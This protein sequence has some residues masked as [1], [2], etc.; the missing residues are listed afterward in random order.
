MVEMYREQYRTWLS[1]ATVDGHRG[2]VLP[3]PYN[4]RRTAATLTPV[5]KE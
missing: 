2:T 4:L 3:P 5:A 1:V